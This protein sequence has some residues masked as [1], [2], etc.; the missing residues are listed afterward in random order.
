[1]EPSQVFQPVRWCSL[2]H[3]LL[4][5][6]TMEVKHIF[7]LNCPEPNLQMADPEGRTSSRQMKTFARV[8]KNTNSFI[9]AV[10]KCFIN[11]G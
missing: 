8:R 2:I 10:E 3:L 9:P 1:M 6:D 11:N 5:D 7:A 4:I